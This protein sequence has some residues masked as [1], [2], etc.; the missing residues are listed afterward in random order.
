VDG[1]DVSVE[2]RMPNI[3][4]NISPIARNA[5]LRECLVRM[6]RKLGE[7]G[8][9]VVEGRDIGT[10]VFPLAKFK[11]YLDATLPE[12]AKRRFKELKEK[13]VEANF[14][15]VKAEIQDRD[16]Q[17]MTRQTAPLYKAEDAIYIDTTNLT[18]PQVVKK[19]LKEIKKRGRDEGMGFDL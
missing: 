10:V 2:I 17:D 18:I 16:K 14:E 9:V 1:V 7:G 6:Q 8:E 19:I 4:K 5:N 3:D 12:R 13:G 15:D 11:F